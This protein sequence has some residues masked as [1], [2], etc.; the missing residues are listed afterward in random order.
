LRTTGVRMSGGVRSWTDWARETRMRVI[1]SWW[2]VRYLERGG[3]KAGERR[4]G[5]RR[6]QKDVSEEKRGREKKSKNA[7]DDVGVEA[8]DTELVSPHDSREELHDEDLV[9]KRVVLV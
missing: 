6:D 7:L 2:W 1:W 8:E 9:V 3:R 4:G 5:R